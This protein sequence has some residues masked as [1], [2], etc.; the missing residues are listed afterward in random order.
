MDT[1][2]G[3]V[4]TTPCKHPYCFDCLQ[5]MARSS[6]AGETG[7]FPPICCTQPLPKDLVRKVL[8]A[9]DW[10]RYEEKLRDKED[11]LN[12]FCPNPY[13]STRLTEKDV[14]A[15]IGTCPQCWQKLCTICKG[16]EHRGI[17][18]ENELAALAQKERWKGCPKCGRLIAKE[19]GT[20]NKMICVCGQYY[21]YR[22]GKGNTGRYEDAMNGGCNCP[23]WDKEDIGV[24]P[25]AGRHWRGNLWDFDG[26][27]A[28]E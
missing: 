18:K 15:E 11:T 6:I 10:A 12:L 4:F 7:S 19:P 23:V 8:T 20:C 5:H 3:D 17:C 22:C 13:C 2:E 24:V 1:I 28:N 25:E 9:R 14:K 21:C 16:V 26:I 27:P